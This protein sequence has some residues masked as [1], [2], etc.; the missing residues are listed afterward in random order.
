MW[1]GDSGCHWGRFLVCD[2]QGLGGVP[3]FS[4]GSIS[5]VLCTQRTAGRWTERADEVWDLFPELCLSSSVP[6]G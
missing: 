1:A 4:G 5:P 6:G 3:G 2:P